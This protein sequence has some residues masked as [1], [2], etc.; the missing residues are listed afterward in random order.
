MLKSI[1][2]N[3]ST[4]LAKKK[5]LLSKPQINVRKKNRNNSEIVDRKNTHNIKA[6]KNKIVTIINVN[7]T[8]TYDHVLQIRFSHNLKKRKISNQI[9]Q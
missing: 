4:E 8:K 2:I 3:K 9:I 7:V 1:I 6:K 5:L